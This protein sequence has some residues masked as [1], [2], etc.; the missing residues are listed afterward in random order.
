MKLSDL[1]HL[2]DQL[3]YHVAW[4][5]RSYLLSYVRND[6][7]N[8]DYI[9]RKFN[10]NNPL[11]MSFDLSFADNIEYNVRNL[12]QQLKQSIKTI[13]DKIAEESVVYHKPFYSFDDSGNRY[14][15]LLDFDWEINV[16]KYQ[17]S[18]DLRNDVMG[19]I[20]KY[21]HYS[22]PALEI[23]PGIA[24]WTDLLVASD[25][26]YLIDYYEESYKYISKKFSEA[27]LRRLRF[28]CNKHNKFDFS[29]LPQNQFGF[30]FS[31]NVFDYYTLESLNKLLA[32]C[33]NVLRPGGHMLFSYNNCEITNNIKTVEVGV[34]SFLT[35][36]LIKGVCEV[37]GFE[38]IENRSVLD[39]HYCI[40]KKTGDL[41]TIKLQQAL[42]KII[43]VYS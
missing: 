24:N 1:S 35:V 22:Y 38:F 30:I 19:Q 23:G 3:F 5:E 10:N 29:M 4:Q 20:Y 33:Y 11:G 40:I 15:E 32:Q 41:T 43:T 14:T 9:L 18:D 8:I 42:G 31:W 25:P 36:D 37:L 34:K 13:S 21:S 27:Y 12:D 2:K 17:D 16:K 26:L 7:K 28:Y 39:Q 6:L